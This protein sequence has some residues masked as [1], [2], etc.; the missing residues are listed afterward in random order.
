ML[1][2]QFGRENLPILGAG[3]ARAVKASFEHHGM[4][5]PTAAEQRRRVVFCTRLALELRSSKHWG[6]RRIADQLPH[7]LAA[8]LKGVPWEPDSRACW[9]PTDGN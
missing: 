8:H 6:T 9:T 3:I 5:N 2:Q 1:V 4:R 7:A